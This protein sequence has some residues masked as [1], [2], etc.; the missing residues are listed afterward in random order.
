MLW[1]YKGSLEG[2]LVWLWPPQAISYVCSIAYLFK[3]SIPKVALIAQS[4]RFSSFACLLLFFHQESSDPWFQ[5]EFFSFSPQV[6]NDP[7][8]EQECYVPSQ[9]RFHPARDLSLFKES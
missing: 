4:F 8:I 1:G 7:W 5:T 6:V 3:K 2:S 9:Q